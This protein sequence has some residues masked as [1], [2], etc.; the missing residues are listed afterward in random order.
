MN[1]KA[2][3]LGGKEENRKYI[4]HSLNLHLLDYLDNYI[5]CVSYLQA[6]IQHVSLYNS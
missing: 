6:I 3:D 1:Y 4:Q 2:L 5:F